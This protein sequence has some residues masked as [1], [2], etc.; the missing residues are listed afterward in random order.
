MANIYS[1]DISIKLKGLGIY[2]VVGGILGVI[3]LIWLILAQQAISIV[4]L[5]L[6]CLSGV[7]FLTQAVDIRNRL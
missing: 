2:Q 4:S 1:K 5:F 3:F 7:L 6:F